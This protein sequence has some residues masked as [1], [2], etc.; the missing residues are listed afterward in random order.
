MIKQAT[1]KPDARIAGIL[2]NSDRGTVQRGKIAIGARATG[3]EITLSYIIVIGKEPGPTLWINGQVH[4][5]EVCAIVAGINF[6][7]DL[8]PKTL[9]GAVVFTAS[10]NPLALESRTWSTQQDFGQ[11]LDTMFPGRPNGFITE[12]MADTLFQEIL[13]VQP[14]LLLSMHAQGTDFESKV[15]GVYKLPPNCVVEPEY[16]YRFMRHFRPYVICHQSVEAGSGEHPGNH[17]GALDYVALANGIPAFMIELGV[18]QRATSE[19]LALG[20]AAYRAI[21][22]ELNMLAHDTESTEPTKSLLVSSRSHCNADSGG[23]WQTT[24]NPG[25][26]VKAGEPL[27]TITSLTGEL[28]ETVTMSMDVLLIA[29]R[30]D[31]VLHTGDSV[32]YLAHDWTEI[33]LS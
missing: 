31:P 24:L 9:K 2:A 27:G 10:G 14:D 5:T 3:A 30:Q 12:R 25:V 18:A 6:C 26:L 33:D 28:V 8:N 19:Q 22:V 13:A 4:G 32:A 29:I 1:N 16:L 11:N 21:C 20:A 23:M 17:A 15:Y 7:N